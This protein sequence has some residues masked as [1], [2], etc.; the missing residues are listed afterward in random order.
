[1]VVQGDRFEVIGVS[2]VA[3][4]EHGAAGRA[5][6]YYFLSPGEGFDLRLRRRAAV[7]K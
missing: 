7:V 3:I 5:E 1:V 6:P 4:Y 2:K